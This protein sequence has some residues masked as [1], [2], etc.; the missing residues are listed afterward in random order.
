MP[1]DSPPA[2][3]K[4]CLKCGEPATVHAWFAKAY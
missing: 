4:K 2:T 3:G 1:F